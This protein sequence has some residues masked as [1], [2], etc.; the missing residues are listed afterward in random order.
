MTTTRPEHVTDITERQLRDVDVSS[1]KICSGPFHR[2]RVLVSDWV[3]TNR[4]GDNLTEMLSYLFK[5]PTSE[6]ERK[7]ERDGD[8]C[9][10]CRQSAISPLT[11][12]LWHSAMCY[13]DWIGVYSPIHVPLEISDLMHCGLHR[14]NGSKRIHHSTVS[15]RQSPVAP[16]PLTFFSLGL[17][18][19]PTPPI[20]QLLMNTLHIVA[21]DKIYSQQA[22]LMFA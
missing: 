14:S 21:S 5:T 10:L 17:P 1:D 9:R 18:A 19:T 20:G 11:R 16:L 3:K 2:S 4:D 6:R 22:G 8:V 15:C 7:K 13:S 12:V